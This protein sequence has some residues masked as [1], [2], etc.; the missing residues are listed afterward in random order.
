MVIKRVMGERSSA[1]W[2]ALACCSPQDQPRPR[3]RLLP[4]WPAASA[5]SAPVDV[6]A[7]LTLYL[8]D[9]RRNCL[10]NELYYGRRLSSFS[11]LSL[12]L[13]VAVVVGSGISGVSG[14][15]IWTTHPELKTVWA[16]I[17]AVATLLAALK[18][19]LNIGAQ[20]KRYSTLFSG[21][22]QLSMSMA[23]V[24]ED[25]AEAHG[26]PAEIERDVERVRS[27][28]KTLAADDDPRPA[29][30]LIQLLQD[31]VNRRVPVTSLDHPTGPE[32]RCSTSIAMGKAWQ[33]N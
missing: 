24:V 18:P 19:V 1:R 30:E 7:K 6:T 32:L 3:R 5:K 2:V 11:R 10:L 8:H 12:G 14:W 31:E 27:R 29:S 23:G 26:V 16:I 13:E 28:H 20:L 15:I 9:L 4:E 21:Y 17:A 25:I 22:R 33:Q